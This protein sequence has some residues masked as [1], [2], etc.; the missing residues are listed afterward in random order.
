MGLYNFKPQFVPFILDGSKSHTIRGPRVRPDEVGN[1]MYL[2][3]G[4]RTKRARLLLK[5]PCIRVE[6]IR[7]VGP[8]LHEG[9]QIFV[10]DELLTR[11][12]AEA[13]AHRD[14][15][16]DVRPLGQMANFWHGRLPF[17]GAIYHWRWR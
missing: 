15:F 9:L 10:D 6:R 5:A 14:G 1:T 12:E 7:I 13:L 17:T 3:T 8:S 2:Y 4:L 11:D 16:R